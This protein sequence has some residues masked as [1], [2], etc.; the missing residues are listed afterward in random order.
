MIYDMNSPIYLQVIEDIKK[1]II[2]GELIAG[3]KLP[4][5]RE[6]ALIYEI[7]PNTAARVYSEMESAGISFTKRGLGTYITEDSEFIGNLSKD[8][9][10]RLVQTFVN[11][12]KVLG[13][14]L[15]DTQK[16]IEGAWDND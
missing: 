12:V 2:K 4:S 13:Y 14:N 5:T 8:A 6:L 7:N 15:D 1:K 16:I 10:L 3:Q 11:E 9:V